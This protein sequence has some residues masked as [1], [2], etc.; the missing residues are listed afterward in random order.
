MSVVCLVPLAVP[1][2]IHNF[3]FDCIS[4]CHLQTCISEMLRSL[5]GHLY[6]GRRA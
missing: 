6:T 2:D 5:V 3:L 1:G 4:S